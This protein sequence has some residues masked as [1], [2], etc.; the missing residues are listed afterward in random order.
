M[1]TA[2]G[3]PPSVDLRIS[4]VPN[5]VAENVYRQVETASEGDVG[6]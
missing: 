3:H 5:L 6:R 2:R 4:N 1:N